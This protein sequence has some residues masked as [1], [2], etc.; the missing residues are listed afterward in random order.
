MKKIIAYAPALILVGLLTLMAGAETRPGC[1]RVRGTGNTIA[2]GPTTFQGSSTIKIG[3]QEDNSAVTTNL[4]GPPK[5][6]EDGTLLAHTSH[7]F[8]FDNGS[9]FTTFDNAVLSPTSTPGLYNLNT[10]AEIIQGT[11][12]YDD[13][14]GALSIHG[15]IN[16]LNGEVVWRFTG[17][18]CN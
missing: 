1:D 4:L 6:T 18:V 7:T 16:F 17:E 14:S 12:D 8:V 10:R 9:S 5:V 3:D 15:T 2:T 11:G 13:A